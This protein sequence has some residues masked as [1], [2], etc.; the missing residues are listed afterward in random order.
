VDVGFVG[1]VAEVTP[2][3]VTALLADARIPVVATVARGT[4]GQVYNVN[5]D[6][7]AA[8]LAVALGAEKLVLLTDVEGLYEQWP[9]P[10]GQTPELISELTAAEL[11][12]RLPE[13][14]EGMVPKMEA[15]LR[16]VRGGVPRAHVLDG[17]L[18]HALLLEIVTDAG[19]GTMVTA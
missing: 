14:A 15:C 9:P 19:V 12:S 8:A 4:D 7:A 13:L 1:D 18:A 5:A 2:D 17:R 16:A 6:T 11:E 3:V 10:P